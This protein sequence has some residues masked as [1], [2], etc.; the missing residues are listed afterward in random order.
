MLS[1][2]F[3]FFATNPA[4]SDSSSCF[5]EESPALKLYTKSTRARTLAMSFLHRRC[6]VGSLCSTRKASSAGAVLCL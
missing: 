4:P 5:F 1:V 6:S 2:F 3:A